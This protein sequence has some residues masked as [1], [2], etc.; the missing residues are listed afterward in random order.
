[1]RHNQIQCNPKNIKLQIKKG[2][3]QN[4]QQ[5]EKEKRDRLYGSYEAFRGQ[6]HLYT[7]SGTL[8]ALIKYWL[9]S[10]IT[11][12]LP[13]FKNLIG[14]GTYDKVAMTQLT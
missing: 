7:Q 13:L 1:M 3:R 5:E 10:I 11:C 14:K 2:D 4:L 8:F 12:F 6:S 9:V